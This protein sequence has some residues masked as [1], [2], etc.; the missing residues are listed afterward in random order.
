MQPQTCLGWG[1]VS[2]AGGVTFKRKKHLQRFF[3]EELFKN[4]RSSKLCVCFFFRVQLFLILSPPWF[5]GTDELKTY[6][7]CLGASP[8]TQ[9]FFKYHVGSQWRCTKKRQ[10][11]G[12]CYAFRKKGKALHLPKRHISQGALKVFVYIPLFLLG[13]RVNNDFQPH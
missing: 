3:L 5:W 12:F 9:A 6:K 8:F 4:D 13:R 2:F 10:T 1:Y 7:L 11:N